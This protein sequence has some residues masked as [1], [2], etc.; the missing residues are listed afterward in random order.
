MQVF[1]E[2][3]M[4]LQSARVVP[5]EDKTHKHVRH[6]DLGARCV[7]CVFAAELILILNSAPFKV[8]S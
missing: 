1:L 3:T 4:S 8:Y 6:S 5:E 2:E 7:R